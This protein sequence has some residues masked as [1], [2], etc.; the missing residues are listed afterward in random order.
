LR[1]EDGQVSLELLPETYAVEAQRLKTT[2]P[3]M[4]WMRAHLPSDARVMSENDP[5]LYL[6]TG[7]RGAKRFPPT[8]YWYR[9]TMKD[10]RDVYL[11][12]PRFAREL[13]FTHL[14]FND[15]DYARDLSEEAHRE[16]I[17]GLKKHPKLELLFE[18]GESHIYRILQ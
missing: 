3:A 10:L 11:D 18:S 4:A 5:M 6:R 15:W 2:E 17:A 9:E 7:L 14:Y 8:I 1:V 12:T 13:G 16:I